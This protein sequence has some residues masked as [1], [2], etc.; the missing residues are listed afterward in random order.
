VVGFV[1]K[2]FKESVLIEALREALS[3][4]PDPAALSYLGRPSHE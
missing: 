4:A 1:V 3:K 2:P